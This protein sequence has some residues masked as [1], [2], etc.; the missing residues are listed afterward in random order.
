MK[1]R[2][3]LYFA[4][5]LAL[6]IV[7]GLISCTQGTR[8]KETLANLS[9]NMHSSYAAEISYNLSSGDF[10][11]SGDAI[12]TKNKANT[13]L[14][15]LT[16]EQYSGLTIDY[17]VTGAPQ[18]VAV[19][20]SGIDTTLPNLALSRINTI[21]QLFSEDFVQVLTMQGTDKISE[22]ENVNTG[23]TEYFTQVS[24]ANS[25]VG[26]RLSAQEE[27]PLYFEFTSDELSGNITFESFEIAYENNK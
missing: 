17:D 3:T 27:K 2:K 25:L 1:T 15:L 26:V 12:I 7:A 13:T 6:L 24:F 22:V 9:D 19:H 16:P 23:E 10:I 5:I 14:K 4:L 21:A 18:S 8:K 11:L 20:F